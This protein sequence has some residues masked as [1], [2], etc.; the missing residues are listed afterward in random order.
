MV[1]SWHCLGKVLPL[2]WYSRGRVLRLKKQTASVVQQSGVVVDSRGI[3]MDDRATVVLQLYYSLT[4]VV[5][6][7]YHCRESA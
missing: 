3:V 1:R 4:T 5:L 7:S 2:S 6:L